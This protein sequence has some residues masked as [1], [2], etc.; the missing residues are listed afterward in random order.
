MVRAALDPE[1]RLAHDDHEALRLWLRLYT[2]ATMNE[3]QVDSMLKRE[4]GSSLPRFDL[5]SQLE[6]APQGLRMSELSARMLTTGGN[7]TW[8]ATALEKEG[9]VSRRV[10][11]EDRRA[12]LVRLTPTGRRHFGAMARAH[13]RLITRTFDGLTAAERRSLHELLGTLKARFRSHPS[14]TKDRP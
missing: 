11:P 8:L 6:R 14:A 4:F 9:F 12:T 2:C 5:L 1:T 3:R 10:A 13:E 7:V